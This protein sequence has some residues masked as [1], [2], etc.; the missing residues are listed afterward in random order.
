MNIV[1]AGGTAILS[2]GRVPSTAPSR[3]TGSSGYC[4]FLLLN[5][6]V[7][8]VVSILG[9]S[10]DVKYVARKEKKEREVVVRSKTPVNAGQAAIVANGG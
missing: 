10:E 5:T 9:Q 1:N 7:T 8:P 4:T 3:P 2:T 6:E